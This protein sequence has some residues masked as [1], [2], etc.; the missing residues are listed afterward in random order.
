M[1]NLRIPISIKFFILILFVV[2]VPLSTLITVVSLGVSSALRENI[3]SNNENLVLSAANA[4]ENKILNYRDILKIVGGNVVFFSKNVKSDEKKEAL[5][6]AKYKYSNKNKQDIRLL[7]FLDKKGKEIAR[8][9]TRFLEDYKQK[10]EFIIAKEKGYYLK[11]LELDSVLGTSTILLS[12][13]LFDKEEFQGVLVS[14]IFLSDIWPTVFLASTSSLDSIYL[15]TEDGNV[16]AENLGGEENLHKK[17]AIIAK[18]IFFDKR[19]ISQ[20]KEAGKEKFLT[21]GVILS[22]LGWKLIVFKPFSEIYE[23]AVIARNQI[24][25]LGLGILIISII[26]ALIFSRIIVIKP[27][28]KFY[29]GIQKIKAG[30]LEHRINIQTGDEIEDLAKGFNQMT[31][32][33]NELNTGLEKKVKERTREAEEEKNK[34]LAVINNFV[35]GLLLLDRENK[36]VLI[37]PEAKNILE[38]NK[39]ESLGKTLLELVNFVKIKELQE[40]LIK[41]E[42]HCKDKKCELMFKQPLEKIFEIRTTPVITQT[43]EAIGTLIILHDVTREKL[44]NRMKSE[45][46]TIAAHQFRTPLTGIKWSLEM[47][48]SEESEMTKE[49]QKDFLDKAYQSNER[50]IKLVNSLLIVSQL[51]EARFIYKFSEIQIEDLIQESIK[52]FGIQ[53]K[54]KNIECV[55]NKPEKP[56]PKVKV[57]LEKIQMALENLI[58]NAIKYTPQNGKIII[59]AIK[60]DGKIK[61]S[62]NDNGMGI[63]KEDQQRLF[64]KFFRSV[65]ALKTETSGSGLG[66]FIVKSIIESN[67]GQIW[68]ESEKE[69]GSTFYFTLPIV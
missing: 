13:P 19:F 28:T 37:N 1:K 29:N 31:A 25:F 40:V 52:D 17:L 41:T 42:G 27:I 60:E 46:I 4:A 48:N 32:K 59:Y 45:F 12:V 62:I 30:D 61:V 51:E 47:L 14:E 49:E 8:T 24:I 57:D 38:I 54:I 35:D 23:P 6:K 68:A 64:T 15:I 39:E 43:Y 63:S 16:V 7:S 53:T 21:T 65:E 67:N 69:K 9:D 26:I 5:L 18:N 56:L 10:P 33:V 22:S 50:M 11:W 3:K 34:T 20:E 66:L 2:I 58:D 36:I 44:I 55:F